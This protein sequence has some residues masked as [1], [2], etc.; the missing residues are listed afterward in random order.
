MTTSPCPACDAPILIADGSRHG[1]IRMPFDP[2]PGIGDHY[3][4]QLAADLSHVVRS[5]AA[6]GNLKGRIPL[7]RAHMWTCTQGM[8]IPADQP[9]PMLQ[10]YSHKAAPRKDALLAAEPSWPMPWEGIK[11]TARDSDDL[12]S[13]EPAAM[14]R[15]RLMTGMALAAYR[16][17]SGQA[18]RRMQNPQPGDLVV[19]T[20][21][22]RK[23][24]GERKGFGV[25]LA[26][27]RE[28]AGDGESRASADAWYVQYGPDEQ[29]V[30]RWEGGAFVAVL[31]DDRSSQ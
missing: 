6:A 14:P 22:A 9:L 12:L 16:S 4:T 21:T 31:T 25:L 11:G 18:A 5:A 15:R 7:Y 13:L 20:A 3:D 28:P 23:P 24:G 26:R 19:E 30:E 8:R 10:G 1:G 29:D 27:R 17:A 2:E